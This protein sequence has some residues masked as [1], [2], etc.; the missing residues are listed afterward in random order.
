M[1]EWISIPDYNAPIGTSCMFCG[2]EINL[3]YLTNA[4]VPAMC[5]ECKEAIKFAKKLMNDQIESKNDQV[6]WKKELVD[7]F[8]KHL[9]EGT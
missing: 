7:D 8:E 9:H 4:L 1:S 6:D 3:G 5:E 2:K